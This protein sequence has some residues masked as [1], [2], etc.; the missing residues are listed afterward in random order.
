VKFLLSYLEEP[1]HGKEL[2]GVGIL[3]VAD[4]RVTFFL[5]LALLQ[6]CFIVLP[7]CSRPPSTAP[8]TVQQAGSKITRWPLVSPRALGAP[9]VAAL[10]AGMGPRYS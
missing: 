5:A 3:R 6:G 9:C 8:A 4:S 7:I 1:S 2:E 10:R